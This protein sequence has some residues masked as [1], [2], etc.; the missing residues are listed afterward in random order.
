M[1]IDWVYFTLL[2]VNVIM[3]VKRWQILGS[4]DRYIALFLCLSAGTELLAW[5]MAQRHMNNLLVYRIYNSLALTIVSMYFGRFVFVKRTAHTKWIVLMFTLFFFLAS[6][7]ILPVSPAGNATFM[8][9]QATIIIVFCL[10]SIRRVLLNTKYLPYRFAHFWLTSLFLLYSSMSFT[11]W[12]VISSLK[13][14]DLLVKVFF[15]LLLDANLGLYTATALVL[16][17]YKKLIP[18]GE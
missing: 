12:G 4:A 8:L 2:L 5:S 7:V 3:S 11:G 15:H 1:L 16:L 9:I 10:F 14:D 18:S 6:T 13:S 17:C